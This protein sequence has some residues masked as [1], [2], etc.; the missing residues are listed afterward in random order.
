MKG[1]VPVSRFL[2]KLAKSLL[3]YNIKF[4]GLGP[5]HICVPLF[6]TT[7]VFLCILTLVFLTNANNYSALQSMNCALEWVGCF[8]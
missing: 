1:N 4:M 8:F 3:P 5:G 6:P 7:G 2:I